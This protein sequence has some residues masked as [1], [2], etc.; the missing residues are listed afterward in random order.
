MTRPYD[1]IELIDT[2]MAA[3]K[4]SVNRLKRFDRSAKEHLEQHRRWFE[5]YVA[6]E[7]RDRERHE[8]RLRHLQ[9]RHQRRIRRQ[10]LIQWC[11]Q[12]AL[13]VALFVRSSGLSVL[14]GVVS[15]LTYLAEL[16]LIS[17]S[18]LGANV[19][20]LARLLIKLL[21]VSFSWVRSKAY[22]LA[23]S[24]AKLLSIGLS[25]SRVKAN[26]FALSLVGAASASFAW[27]Q[28]KSHDLARSTAKL[29]SS[30]LSWSRV[31]ANAFA[32]L[33][34]DAA[35]VSLSWAKPKAY[36]LARSTTKLLWVGL[37]WSRVKART[38]ALSLVDAA[39]VSFS[40]VRSQAYALARSTAKLLSIGLSW[41]RV[42]A[43]ACALL[44]LNL[45]SV[46]RSWI[47]ARARDLASSLPKLVSATRLQ[48]RRYRRRGLALAG[49]LPERARVGL[50]G[51]HRS[52]EPMRLALKR[53][54]VGSSTSD[55]G[56]SPDEEGSSLIPKRNDH[57]EPEPQH[58]PF[59][60]QEPAQEHIAI[61]APIEKEI[62]AD[63]PLTGGAS[64]TGSIDAPRN[65]TDVMASL[66]A[67]DP[68]SGMDV[69]TAGNESPVKARSRK[70]RRHR[71][72][73]RRHASHGVPCDSHTG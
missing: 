10:R 12:L 21:A 1:S 48:A 6:Q 23:R 13:A 14:K 32:L 56:P 37:S 58:A 53:R 34:F 42:K 67:G 39:S 2:Q 22:A 71:K 54:L 65:S 57:I 38:V 62:I 52:T 26:A 19:Y 40:W 72:R 11:K 4:R 7:T 35:S 64:S 44:L 60:H 41:S 46:S 33:V 73:R 68:V 28:G 66:V 45:A 31:K 47:V 61:S 5:G 69:Q 17:A 36:A 51:F 29:L 27:V 9:L 24:T 43:R 8:R 3:A 20:A 70:R 55:S 25:W 30:G 18:W 63:K 49:T 15:A 59:Q 50:Q 16:L